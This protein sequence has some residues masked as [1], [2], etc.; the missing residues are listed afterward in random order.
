MKILFNRD[1]NSIRMH[2][3]WI[4]LYNPH[5]TAFFCFRSYYQIIILEN[6]LTFYNFLQFY[7]IFR[8]SHYDK[9]FNDTNLGP[10][11]IYKLSKFKLH[12][13]LI[14]TLSTRIFDRHSLKWY[15][16]SNCII[17]QVGYLLHKILWEFH[18]WFV[19]L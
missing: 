18:F 3:A 5:S 2:I 9:F 17:W 14:S 12:L 1:C 6:I 15:K 11:Y 10:F 7:Y 4:L 19:I 16:I 8:V 13:I